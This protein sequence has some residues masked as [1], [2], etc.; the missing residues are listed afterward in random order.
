MSENIIEGRARARTCTK[1]AQDARPTMTVVESTVSQDTVQYLEELLAMAR[2][3][4]VIGVAY[5]AMLKR[6]KYIANTA[7]EAHRNPT[8]TRGM[9][10][11]LDD[12][13]GE[14]VR[15]R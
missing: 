13:L 7:G 1:P 12:D 5:V 15:R 4:E 3:G 9:L 2:A 10:R 11:A 14:R 8:F 6:R